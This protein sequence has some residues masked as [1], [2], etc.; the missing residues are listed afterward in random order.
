MVRSRANAGAAL[1]A[2]LFACLAALGGAAKVVELSPNAFVNMREKSKKLLLVEFYSPDCYH[3]RQLDPVLEETAERLGNQ[4]TVI[5]IDSRSSHELNRELKVRGTPTML[6]FKNGQEIQEAR[7]DIQGYRN[8]DTLAAFVKKHIRDDVV[9][10]SSVDEVD[11][12]VQD[13]GLVVLGLFNNATD[14]YTQTFA[15]VAKRWRRYM[16]FAQV[17]DASKARLFAEAYEIDD[18]PSMFIVKKRDVVLQ[19]DGQLTKRSD[20]EDFVNMYGF[21]LVGHWGVLTYYRYKNRPTPRVLLFHAAN[22]PSELE[23][24]INVLEEVAA[25]YD[26]VSFM[27]VA[28]D[29]AE[30]DDIRIMHKMGVTDFALPGLAAVPASNDGS[31]TFDQLQ[32]FTLPNVK[33]FVEKWANGG[34]SKASHKCDVVPSANEREKVYSGELL[35]NYRSFVEREKERLA[36]LDSEIREVDEYSFRKVAQKSWRDILTIYTCRTC[37]HSV[38]LEDT[39]HKMI[40]RGDLADLLEE[41]LMI[42]K[43]DVVLTKTLPQNHISSLPA[44]KYT[45]ARYRDF[46]NWFQGSPYSPEDIFQFIRAYHSMRHIEIPGEGPSPFSSKPE[47]KADAEELDQNLAAIAEELTDEEIANLEAM[48][49]NAGFQR[50]EF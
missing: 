34:F 7:E 5:K 47:A 41:E 39:I 10:V 33:S 18:V 29:A 42:V 32:N 43:V 40:R 15:E 4:V 30:A 50:D 28:A 20:M 31:M 44:L 21:P 13:E 49:R 14:K 24:A 35:E 8:V 22:H 17:A 12:M 36:L 37:L 48:A 2:A 23:D 45:S 46:P 9:S 19:Y 16:P 6:L 26:E 1:A 11:E 3:C 38:H 25:D 27:T